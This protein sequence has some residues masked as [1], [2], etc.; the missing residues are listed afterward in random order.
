MH[1]LQ[2]HDAW[3][4]RVGSAMCSRLV[5]GLYAWQAKC[6]SFGRRDGHRSHSTGLALY[7]RD[8]TLT[9]PTPQV[10]GRRD[11]LDVDGRRWQRV[12]LKLLQVQLLPARAMWREAIAAWSTYSK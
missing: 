8:M 9:R 11:V 10:V 6:T 7:T 1:G 2:A 4:H 5:H 12:V 3:W